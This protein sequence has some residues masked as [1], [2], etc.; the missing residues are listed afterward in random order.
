MGIDH[1]FG[2]NKYGEKYLCVAENKQ[3]ERIL[4]REVLSIKCVT[5]YIFAMYKTFVVA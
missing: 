4:S 3:T 2:E 5:Y 1:Q